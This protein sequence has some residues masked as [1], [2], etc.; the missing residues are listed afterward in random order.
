MSKVDEIKTEIDTD[1]IPRTYS[2][3][4]DQQVMD[5]MN[6]TIDRTVQ[7]PVGSADLLAW[8]GDGERYMKLKTTSEN[9]AKSDAVRSIAFAAL[10][11]IN[12]D[13][14]DFDFSLADRVAMLDALV[15]DG[16]LAAADKTALEALSNT[17]VS[18][19]VELGLGVIRLGE[20]AEA[21]RL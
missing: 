11:M 10:A 4:T 6:L 14:T 5:S 1:P 13:G 21:R 2:G 18:R 16:T 15:T 20:V 12:R 8:A 19:G 7:S 3:M 17:S 9:V